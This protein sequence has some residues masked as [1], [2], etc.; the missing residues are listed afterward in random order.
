S[1][2]QCR[3][4]SGNGSRK[5]GLMQP[6]PNMRVQ[7]TRAA[8]FARTRSP[9]TRSPLGSGSSRLAGVVALALLILG[10]SGDSS[11]V[12]TKP[13]ELRARVV[14]RSGQPI[15]GVTVTLRTAGEVVGT[16]ISDPKGRVGFL[17]LKAGDYTLTFE[18][19]GFAT[20]SIGPVKMRAG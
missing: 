16:G 12:W 13:G 18:I 1:A 7:R 2:V 3:R 8:R 6:W 4:L 17:G 19:A 11:I 5:V 14:N 15:S 10:M 9:L 20:S